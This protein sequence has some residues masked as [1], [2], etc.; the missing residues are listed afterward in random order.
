MPPEIAVASIDGTSLDLVTPP[1]ATTILFQRRLRLG[2]TTPI[3]LLLPGS[4][5]AGPL[6]G[7][8][9]ILGCPVN[10]LVH[11]Q[12]LVRHRCMRRECP[13]CG[14]GPWAWREAVAAHSRLVEWHH[15]VGVFFLPDRLASAP[16]RAL[17]RHVTLSEDAQ[18]QPTTKE[19]LD[20]LYARAYAVLGSMGFT[21][22]AIVFHPYRHDG[23]CTWVEGPHFHAVGFGLVNA[24]DR[25][26]GWVVRDVTLLRDPDG[27]KRSW[28][29][30]LKYVLDHSLVP[31]AADH[32]YHS[33]RWFGALSYTKFSSRDGRDTTTA[34]TDF[35]AECGAEMVPLDQ[36]LPPD[37]L[38]GLEIARWQLAHRGR[39]REE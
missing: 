35:C 13:D 27:K 26:A 8:N 2:S 9:I 25:P 23:A 32:R 38:D 11:P 3:D 37:G 6:C 22:G 20:A 17:L 19:A 33:L 29:A 28:L 24:E 30:T 1:D 5:E 21:G 7:T 15:R 4:G 10:P 14:P 16:A 12:R 39:F 34:R 31:R 18:E 36:L